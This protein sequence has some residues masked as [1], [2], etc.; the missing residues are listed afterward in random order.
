[1]LH[2]APQTED[3]QTVFRRKFHQKLAARSLDGQEF[4]RTVEEIMAESLE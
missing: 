2:E 3:A 4:D 1:M